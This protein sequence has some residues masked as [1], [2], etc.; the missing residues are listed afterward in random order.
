MELGDMR[1]RVDR[2]DDATQRSEHRHGDFAGS[3]LSE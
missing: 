3:D 2:S 1:E